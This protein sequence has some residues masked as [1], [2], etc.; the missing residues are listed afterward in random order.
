MADGCTRTWAHK[1]VDSTGKPEG[2]TFEAGVETNDIVFSGYAIGLYNTVCLLS[3][4]NLGTIIDKLK[5]YLNFAKQTQVRFMYSHFLSVCRLPFCLRDNPAD[6]EMH[7]E[8]A[9]VEKQLNYFLDY[10][11]TSGVN[12]PLTTFYIFN[13]AQH[14]YFGRYR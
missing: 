4:E 13:G 6:L 2:S 11:A 7:G 14:Y 12:L 1:Y 9:D 3:G 8:Y 5:V 10:A